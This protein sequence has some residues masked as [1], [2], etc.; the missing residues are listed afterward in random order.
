VE[1]ELIRRA[2]GGDRSAFEDLYRIHRRRTE[3][4][5]SARIWNR[6]DVQDLTQMTFLHA[7]LGLRGYRGQAAFSTWLNRIAMNLCIS[8]LRSRATYRSFLYV[9]GATYPGRGEEWWVPAH[10]AD[11]ETILH[12]EESRRAVEKALEDI[13]VHY[14]EALRMR[15]VEDRDYAFITRRLRVPPG[16]AKTWIHRG[17]RRLR[18]ALRSRIEGGLQE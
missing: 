12:R 1:R 16:T 15:F 6:E 13:P 18:G 14:R 11:P 5:I 8:H 10:P 3:A 2:L 9:G 17:R 4:V 7:Y